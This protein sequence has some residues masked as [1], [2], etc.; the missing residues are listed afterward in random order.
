MYPMC[1]NMRR[2]AMRRFVCCVYTNTTISHMAEKDDTGAH[3]LWRRARGIDEFMF[4][5]YVYYSAHI[6]PARENQASGD[7]ADVAR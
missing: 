7:V 3:M 1:T 2:D 4:I 5:L 6:A